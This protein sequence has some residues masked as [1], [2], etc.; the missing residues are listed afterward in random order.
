MRKTTTKN[1][2]SKPKNAEVPPDMT[3]RLVMYL[4]ALRP[5]GY[6][7]Y[8][9]DALREAYDKMSSELDARVPVNKQVHIIDFKNKIDAIA[10]ILGI[11][12]RIPLPGGVDPK[13]RRL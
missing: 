5:Y 11:E 12:D 4:G 2:F 6:V 1:C 3:G 9:Y 10:D 8:V 13:A 7:L